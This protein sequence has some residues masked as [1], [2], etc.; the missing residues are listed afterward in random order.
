MTTV[1]CQEFKECAIS[2]G[3]LASSSLHWGCFIV[4]TQAEL[5]TVVASVPEDSL[6]VC[7]WSSVTL[8]AGIL[9]LSQNRFLSSESYFLLLSH[10]S[11]ISHLPETYIII[12]KGAQ[13][14]QGQQKHGFPGSYM[15][16]N[17]SVSGFNLVKMALCPSPVSQG[18]MALSSHFGLHQV[19]NELLFFRGS[20]GGCYGQTVTAREETDP[21]VHIRAE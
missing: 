9:F 5:T 16:L 11:N 10:L 6:K 4:R 1:S 21:S 20:S 18:C 7:L 3:C 13:S 14:C 12:F 19:F 15:L 17:H 2:A 8:A